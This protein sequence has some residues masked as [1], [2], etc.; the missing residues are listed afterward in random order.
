MSTT[1]D[2]LK[3]GLE[4]QVTNAERQRSYAESEKEILERRFIEAAR[5]L[6]ER[7]ADCTTA[8]R[9]L[10]AFEQSLCLTCGCLK[11]DHGPNNEDPQA[12]VPYYCWD[13][14]IQPNG[15]GCEEPIL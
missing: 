11:G 15:E 8:R 4:T 14:G 1:T 9:E 2:T 10:A 3:Y 12:R 5:D 7:S 6:A 13:C